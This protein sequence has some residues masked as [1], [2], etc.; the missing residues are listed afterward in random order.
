MEK[1]G[2]AVAVQEDAALVGSSVAQEASPGPGFEGGLGSRFDRSADDDG[3]RSEDGRDDQMSRSEDGSEREAPEVHPGGSLS[4]LGSHFERCIQEV[5]QLQRRRDDL[6]REL[7]RLEQPMARE[8]AALRAE[9]AEAFGQLMGVQLEQ[10]RLREETLLVKRRLFVTTRDCIQSQVALAT[11]QHDVAQFAITQEELQAQ[12]L[13]LGQEVSRLQEAQ[14][15]RLGASQLRPRFRPRAHSDLTAG[16]R[17]SLELQQY[18]RG[19]MSFLQEWYEP[20]LLALLRRRQAGEEALRTSRELSQ[21]LR[22][23]LGPLREHVQKLELRRSCLEETIAL[24][25][26]ERKENVEQ[27]RE[28]LD[29]LE[30]ALR[31]LRTELQVQRRRNKKLET[32][33]S[34]LEQEAEAYRGFIESL[35]RTEHPGEQEL[36][37]THGTG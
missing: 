9:M 37:G 34:R 5:G 31:H 33:N 36:G 26:L 29:T 4:E 12:I 16:R 8:V 2:A 1:L 24:M 22:A 3:S 6:V 32:T 18:L 30:E 13:Q 21:D 35:G 23:Q 27:C 25:E 7:L 11:Q 10:R 20:R 14:Q 19:G 28:T 17:A 15:K